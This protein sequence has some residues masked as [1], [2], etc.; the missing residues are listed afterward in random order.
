LRR[1]CFK[2]N[3]FL[4]F[5]KTRR[6]MLRLLRLYWWWLFWLPGSVSTLAA[7]GVEELE[8]STFEVDN[9]LNRA[10]DAGSDIEI[11][12]LANQSLSISRDLA[13]RRRHRAGLCSA[14]A[15]MR[16]RTGRTQDALRHYLG[17][18]E[19]LSPGGMHQRR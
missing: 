1:T 5:V 2:P 17:A 13:L 6:S 15:G 19:K 10:R 4:N 18:E 7:Q 16:P 14:G 11:Y 3:V 8:H 9:L 12:S